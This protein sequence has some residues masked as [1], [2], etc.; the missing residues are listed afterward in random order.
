MKNKKI[1]FIGTTLLL[2][3]IVIV[4]SLSTNDSKALKEK[5][6]IINKKATVESIKFDD[7]KINIYF[8]WGDGCPHCEEEYE[9]WDSIIDDYKN[10]INHIYGLEVWNN[11]ENAKNMKEFA[12]FKGDEIK[13]VPYTIIGDKTF[14]G[15]D[16]SMKKQMKKKINEMYKNS[17]SYDIYKEMK[18]K[19]EN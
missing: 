12:K 4:L 1:I 7:K 3:I 16:K 13:G 10:K 5:N 11:K 18:N 15:F 19:N 17:N 9:F 6:K 2:I 8:F 14:V